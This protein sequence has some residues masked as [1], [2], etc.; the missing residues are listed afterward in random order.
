VLGPAN[1][2]RRPSFRVNKNN[3]TAS[4]ST[5]TKKSQGIV[6]IRP[7]DYISLMPE[8]KWITSGELSMDCLVASTYHNMINLALGTSYNTRI[9]RTIRVASIEVLGWLRND[10]EVNDPHLVRLLMVADKDSK[11]ALTGIADVLDLGVVAAPYAMC[12]TNMFNAKRIRY[13][14]DSISYLGMY[15]DGTIDENEP[16]FSEKAKKLIHFTVKPNLL[17]EFN[18]SNNATYQDVISNNIVFFCAA[19]TDGLAH[20][21]YATWNFQYRISFYDS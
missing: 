19:D 12:L 10:F 14:H 20:T 15:Q 11:A 6:R 2:S 9:G 3:K 17:I 8:L 4:S 21:S 7:R 5:G 13:L 1:Y 18:S 16:N